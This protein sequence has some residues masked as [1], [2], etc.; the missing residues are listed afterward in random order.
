MR[1]ARFLTA[2]LLGLF[3]L[4]PASS[5]AQVDSTY[6][7]FKELGND[8]WT[9]RAWNQPVSGDD[10]TRIERPEGWLPDWWPQS[11]RTRQMELAAYQD[12]LAAADSSGWTIPQQ[13][14]YRLL[15]SALARVDWE[16][17]INADWQR[18]P[19]F[20]VH[21]TLG[22]IF[23]L[24]LEP[25]PF[26]EGRSNDII[27][28]LEHI[29]TTVES[30]KVN[31]DKSVRVFA[32]LAI[33]ELEQAGPRLDEFERTISSQLVGES[34]SRLEFVVGVAKESLE[35][36]RTWL[37]R[38][39]AYMSKDTALGRD[40]YQFFLNYVALMPYSPE[41][42]LTMARLEWERSV[43]FETIEKQRNIFV[44]ELPLAASQEAQ[45]ETNRQDELAVRAFLED[46]GILTVPVW[47]QHYENL[48]LPDYLAPFAHLGVIDDLTSP[49]RLG[50]N[51]V[52]YIR[53]PSLDLPYFSL[54]TARDSRPILV[55]EGI[56]GHYFQLALSWAQPDTLRR[57]YYDSG[58]NE[59]IGFYAEE[60]MLQA[61]YFDDSPKAR[62]I[63]YN[64]MRLRALRVEVDVKLA[65]GEFTIDEAADYLTETVPMDR[66]TAENEAAF[67]ASTPGQ[68]ITYQIGKIQ[69]IK[70]MSDARSALGTAFSLRDFHDFV[71]VNGNVPIALQR[72][73]YL[74]LRDEINRL[75][76]R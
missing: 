4:L 23:D 17:N 72:W 3:L 26:T 25:P 12:Q 24:L 42:L 69:I 63:I 13:V 61:G 71:W 55:H 74:G 32:E 39:L 30:A 9:W 68:A 18:N 51:G 1:I 34:A 29:G 76:G 52:K 64:F 48:P 47:L 33:E 5:Q 16:L 73:E 53:Q 70:F 49:S 21:Q 28:R 65:T 31:L 20:Y 67:F 57:Y 36:F 43:A 50:E 62:E 8:F 46:N 10:I 60:M 35:D 41:E 59:G 44:P 14:N 22:S 15:S 75:D 54:A 45:V 37:E 38:G 11:V 66:T 2:S 6:S 27:A 19:L 58:A 56:P 40:A 7:A